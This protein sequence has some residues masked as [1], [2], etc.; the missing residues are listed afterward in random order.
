MTEMIVADVRAAKAR[1]D[2]VVV[3]FHWG[4]ETQ[5]EPEPYQVR[6]AHAAVE[7][8]ASAIVGSHPHVLQGLERWKGAPVAYSLGNFVFGG[9]WDPK[10][11]RTA[12]LELTFDAQRVLDTKVLPARSDAYP[13]R[14]VQPFFATDAGALEVLALLGERSQAFPEPLVPV[15]ARDGGPFEK[16]SGRAPAPDAG[17]QEM[18]GRQGLRP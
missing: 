4:R 10:D 6:L 17:T 9:N 7:A 5:A 16:A 3:F 13:E 8:G 1:A 11:K 18:P 2:H 14:P 12:L 15:A